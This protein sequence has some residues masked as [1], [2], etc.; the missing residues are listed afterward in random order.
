[1]SAERGSAAGDPHVPDTAPQIPKIQEVL[2]YHEATKHSPESI[3]RSRWAMDWSNKPYPFKRYAGLPRI[4]LEREDPTP[5]RPALEAIA[6]VEA[7]S[8]V[9]AVGFGAITRL[10]TWGAGLHHAVRHQD[11]QTFSFRTYA[12]AGALYPVEVYLV[13][14][15]LDGLG[16]GVYHNLPHGDQLVRLREGDHRPSLVRASADDPAVVHS[17]VVLALTGM[18]WRSAWKYAE[19]GYRHLFWD[20]GMIVANLLALAASVDV[21]ARVVVGFA[22]REVELLFGHDGRREV[23]LCLLP[24]GT[25]ER[26]VVP[27]PGPPAEIGLPTLPLS[28]TEYAFEAITVAN[29]AGRL[30][31]PEEVERWRDR[32]GASDREVAPERAANTKDAAAV[33]DGV[34]DVI[35]RRGSARAFGSVAM[36]REILL[37]VLGRATC[38]VRSDHAP[39]GSRLIEPYLVVNRVDGLKPGAYVWRDGEPRLLRE[40]DFRNQAAFLCLEQRLGGDAS[41]T[42]FLMADLPATFEKLGARGYRTAQLEAGTVAGK[43]YLASYAHRLGATGLTFFDDEVERFFSPDAVGKSCMLV[44][45]VGDSPRLHRGG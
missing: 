23:P 45:A 19:R 27:A 41:V 20:A 21:P 26:E 35:R 40:G 30:G 16:A 38:G 32:T 10:L 7:E 17:P 22:D 14:G 36:P 44:V 25:S 29:D 15:E 24:L 43:V 33:T 11:G 31:S 6:R 2:A 18:P 8:P 12:S 3:R 13:C 5:S 28:R 34:E 39:D 9:K 37:D 42:V 4:V 1:M